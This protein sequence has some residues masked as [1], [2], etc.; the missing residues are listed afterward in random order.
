MSRGAPSEVTDLL[1][2]WSG[3]DQA[4][5]APLMDEVYARLLR[6]AIS[7]LKH[8]RREHTLDG[9]A[10]VN[11]AFLRFVQQD[12]VQWQNR[13]H[14]FAVSAKIMRRVLLDHA[15]RQASRKRGPGVLRITI[16]EA[17][18]ASLDAA[19]ERPPDL[20]ALDDA[21]RELETRNPQLAELVVMR[22]FGGM[23]KEEVAEVMG[24]SSATV[25]RRWRTRAFLAF[26]VLERARRSRGWYGPVK[27][28]DTD[29]DLWHQGKRTLRESCRSPGRA[30]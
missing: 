25:S 16:D 22:Y 18:D 15:R 1:L 11:E 28:S 6:L 24:L 26:R 30:A 19:D 21:L 9:A 5:L 23:R 8:E 7:Y 27:E 4:A 10:L 14:F 2:A 3:G 12:R 13:A 17:V 20:I 29:L